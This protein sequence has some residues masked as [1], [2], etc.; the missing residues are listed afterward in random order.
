[1]ELLVTT[2]A[3]S[4]QQ[5]PLKTTRRIISF[6]EVSRKLPL[7]WKHQQLFLMRQSLSAETTILF[8]YI[9]SYF[10]GGTAKV[11][12]QGPNLLIREGSSGECVAPNDRSE[13][14]DEIVMMFRIFRPI[15]YELVNWK[16]Y[17]GVVEFSRER[18][19]NFAFLKKSNFHK[20][21]TTIKLLSMETC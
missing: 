13:K 19:F 11:M 15:R 3:K 18:Y 1:M 20:N 8:Y 9:S 6:N 16:G 4:Q 10:N 21:Y 2:L 14:F 17:V 5:P 12:F 7:C